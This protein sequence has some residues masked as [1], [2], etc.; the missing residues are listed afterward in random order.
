[1]IGLEPAQR[2][3]LQRMQQHQLLDLLSY[4]DKCRFGVRSPPLF[5]ISQ[6][7]FTLC[8]PDF[9]VNIFFNGL[10]S[11]F[12]SSAYYLSFPLYI[13]YIYGPKI[14]GGRIF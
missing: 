10:L 11:L 6:D 4:L 7:L 3:C 14:K 5:D 13:L 12:L 8:Y 1:M 2:F 9:L